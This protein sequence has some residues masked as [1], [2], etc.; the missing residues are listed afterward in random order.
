MSAIFSFKARYCFGRKTLANWDLRNGS[1]DL[2]VDSFNLDF[3][4]GKCCG[5][6]LISKPTPD[7]PLLIT[8][9]FIFEGSVD[10]V[11]LITER[12][13]ELMLTTGSMMGY[14]PIR[15]LGLEIGMCCEL[16]LVAVLATSWDTE[17]WLATGF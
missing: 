3:K 14:L 8:R 11:L 5:L 7:N 13:A 10:V 12:Y 6:M 17:L 2:F 1:G 16:L 9:S 4:I 15:V